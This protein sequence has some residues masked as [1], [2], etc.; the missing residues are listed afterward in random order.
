MTGI[1]LQSHRIV[2]FWSMYSS[3]SRPTSGRNVDLAQYPVS[4]NAENATQ[5]TV[6]HTYS[7]EHH[8]DMLGKHSATLF[9]LRRIFILQYSRIPIFE[10]DVYPPGV[11]RTRTHQS[12]VEQIELVLNILPFPDDWPKIFNND[13]QGSDLAEENASPFLCTIML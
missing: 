8:L 2:F 6:W 5:V 7:N 9:N 12:V 3:I 13:K 1:C 11:M 4:G 10:S